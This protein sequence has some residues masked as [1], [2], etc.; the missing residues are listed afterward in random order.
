MDQSEEYYG[1]VVLS[2]IDNSRN[3][4]NVKEE[5]NNIYPLLTPN[6]LKLVHYPESQ[7]LVIWL[8]DSGRLYDTIAIEDVNCNDIIWNK[9][10]DD[11][12]SGSIQ[13]IINTLFLSPGDFRVSIVK[14]DSLVHRIY[15]KKY[16]QGVEPPVEKIQEISTPDVE[17]GPIIYR[18]GFGNVLPDEDLILRDKVIEKM[19]AKFNRRVEF[20][21]TVR[22]GTVKYIEGSRTISFYAEMGG[23][24]CIFYIDI[25]TSG[26]WEELTGFKLSEREEIVKFVAEESV[27]KQTRSSGIYYLIGERDIVIMNS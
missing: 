10:V 13:L 5:E 26:K 1:K 15:L 6:N 22:S 23:G 4:V 9:K 24:N 27:R 7:Q 14:S 16:P 17:K 12:L 8:P 25:P 11:I 19:Q 21:G 3:G 2:S 18:D 20:D